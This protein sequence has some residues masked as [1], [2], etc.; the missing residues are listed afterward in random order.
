MKTNT[1]IFLF[2]GVLV[3]IFACRNKSE[4]KLAD[5]EKQ[6]L[7][8]G[9]RHDSLFLGLSLGMTK[10]EFCDYCLNMNKKGI[11]TEGGDKTVEY[12]LGK[13]NFHFPLQMNFYPHFKEDKIIDLPIKFT[14]KGIDLSYP[15]GQTEKL[16]EDVKKLTEEWYGEGFFITP[17]PNGGKGYAKV[18]GNRCV[19]I[20][21]EKEFE[22][23]VIVKD[24]TADSQ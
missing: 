13:K 8:T 4:K 20:F 17:L 16:A 11:F 5:V 14:Y 3:L 12:V 1:I 7:A 22:V 15:N 24:L 23:M 9:I 6:E 19:L 18:S 10:R 2:L 21:S